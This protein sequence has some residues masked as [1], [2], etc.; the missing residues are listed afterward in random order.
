MPLYPE[1]GDIALRLLLTVIVSL[2]IGFERGR[3]GKAAGMRTTLLVGL[4][5]SLTMIESNLLLA[6][7]GRQADFFATA[8]VMRLPLGILTGVGFIGAGAILRR[9]DM[10]VGVTT[11]GTLWFVTVLGLCFGA[12]EIW[13]GLAGFVLGLATIWGLESVEAKLPHDREARLNIRYDHSRVGAD[14][15]IAEVVKPPYA[16]LHSGADLSPVMGTAEIKLHLRWRAKGKENRLPAFV[17]TLARREGVQHV[18]W[19]PTAIAA[20]R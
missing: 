19:E 17:E 10:I 12:G 1:I 5:A 20:D 13:L 11:A 16:L 4:A 6:T 7:H 15:L 14:A 2:A 18:S 8:D 3:R 9:S